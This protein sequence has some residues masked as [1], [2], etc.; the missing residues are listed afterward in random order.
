MNQT[1]AMTPQTG[2]D[3][4][5]EIGWT[6]LTIS[7]LERSL[8]FYIEVLGFSI[9]ERREHNAVLGAGVDPLLILA[10]QRGALP[11]PAR[12]TGLY[13]FA[14]LVPSRRDLARSLRQLTMTRYPLDGY[15]DHLVSEAL[16]LS[17]PDGN[18]IEIYRDR[19]RNEWQWHDGMVQMASDPIDLAG[20]LT[21]AERDGQPWD[22]LPAGTRIGHIHLQVADIQQAEVFYHSVLGFDVV[23]RWPGAL[24]VSAGGYHH[25]LG[26]NTWQSRNAP[27]PPANAAGLRAFTIVV[28]TEAA[29]GQVAERLQAAEVPY[30][31]HAH[32]MAFRDPWH[33]AIVLTPRAN[34]AATAELVVGGI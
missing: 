27:P 26:L 31:M 3:P 18:G 30:T 23:A 29:Q 10:E 33:N 14:I 1:P 24:F 6:A 20:L 2:I 28:P 25:H 5:T 12:T 34:L 17:D 16:Y 32:G 8:Q 13:H 4:A 11:K 15:A 22:G 7:D 21:E 9:L 19:P